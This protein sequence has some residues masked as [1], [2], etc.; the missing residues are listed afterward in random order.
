MLRF[1]LTN[2]K[3]S[4][5]HWEFQSLW[6]TPMKTVHFEVRFF[7][8][9]ISAKQRR[10]QASFIDLKTCFLAFLEEKFRFYW[11]IPKNNLCQ[12]TW[13]IS[14]PWVCGLARFFIFPCFS[15]M[16]GHATDWTFVYG[17]RCI[18][19]L[20][21]FR[22]IHKQFCTPFGIALHAE[23]GLGKALKNHKFQPYYTIVMGPSTSTAGCTIAMTESVGCCLN[24]LAVTVTGPF[25]RMLMRFITSIQSLRDLWKQSRA[26]LMMHDRWH[27]GN[28]CSKG[29]VFQNRLFLLVLWFFLASPVSL[30]FFYKVQLNPR[31]YVSSLAFQSAAQLGVDNA[32]KVK[33]DKFAG[34]YTWAKD[35][36][37]CHE[38]CLRQLEHFSLRVVVVDEPL[39]YQE[40]E[41]EGTICLLLSMCCIFHE[42]IIMEA[43]YHNVNLQEPCFSG[44][45]SRVLFQDP[46]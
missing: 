26:K 17:R 4:Q 3:S 14:W 12:S 27:Q 20:E 23:G 21:T 36:W 10:G 22:E 8:I 38:S 39:I 7:K 35:Q 6:K 37:G 2:W 13:A 15:T 18:W 16:F 45:D 1:L 24:L 5:P 41:F 32:N 31:P 29:L 19:K 44:Y 9:L 40:F 25:C 34:C 30:L 46:V 42:T 43:A 28:W 11:L 33:L